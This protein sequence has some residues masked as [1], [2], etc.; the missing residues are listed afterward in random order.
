[1]IVSCPAKDSTS[2]SREV[3]TTRCVCVLQVIVSRDLP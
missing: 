1:M 2:V 3:D